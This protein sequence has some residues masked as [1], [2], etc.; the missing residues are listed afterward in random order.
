MFPRAAR[1]TRWL[2]ALGSHLTREAAG[3]VVKSICSR[4]ASGDVREK[5]V[6]DGGGDG[7]T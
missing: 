7:R 5:C 3:D 4:E 6:L 1:D 2:S